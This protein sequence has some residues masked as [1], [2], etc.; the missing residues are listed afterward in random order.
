M[1]FRSITKSQR[2]VELS[3]KVVNRFLAITA[4]ARQM[5]ELLAQIAVATHE[6]NQGIGQM[7]TIVREMDGTTQQSA[8]T[9]AEMA[10]DTDALRDHAASLL[11]TVNQLDQLVG[12]SSRPP[13]T[14]VRATGVVGAPR[15]PAADAFRSRS[16]VLKSALKN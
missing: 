2:G 7:N 10:E 9:S 3:V 8:M 16:S 12:R 13:P 15:A 6:Q 4:K 14:R 5:D 1:L 11:Q